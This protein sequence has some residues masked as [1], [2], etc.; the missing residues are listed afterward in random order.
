MPN[1]PRT[2][3]EVLSRRQTYRPATLRAVRA[4][5]R[6]KPWRGTLKQR[7]AKF[8]ALH[9]ELCR[10]YGRS[11]RLTFRIDESRHSGSSCYRPS[12]QRII[13]NGRL[14]SVVTYLHEFAHALYG[15]SERTACRW[16]I[17]LFR[18]CF[19][20]SYNQCAQVG[21]TLTRR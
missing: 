3:R 4:F 1:Y 5:A 8:S 21:H 10:V 13:L 16:S 12:E 19:P 15:R 6:S 9:F 18:R 11:I 17:N 14:L 7:A 20:R 2:V